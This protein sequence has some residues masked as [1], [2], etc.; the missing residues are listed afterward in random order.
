MYIPKETS[1]YLLITILVVLST[2]NL[3]LNE[4]AG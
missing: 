2:Q 3:H 4:G 1:F